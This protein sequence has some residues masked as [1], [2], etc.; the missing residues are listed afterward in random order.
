MSLF[1]HPYTLPA[2]PGERYRVC[3]ILSRFTSQ[4][5]HPLG[6]RGGMIGKGGSGYSSRNGLGP[7]RQCFSDFYSCIFYLF[8][9]QKEVL[10]ECC[11]RLILVR[12]VHNRLVCFVQ[13][14]GCIT[15]YLVCFFFLSV[16]ADDCRHYWR[17]CQLPAWKLDR[18]E[19]MPY[20]EVA[21]VNPLCRA[22]SVGHAA[23]PP[24][25][26]P[27]KRGLTAFTGIGR[28]WI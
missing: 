15:K 16:S 25:L 1:S 18:S 19:A 28:V 21:S 13:H 10:Y 20:T 3:L 22:P 24:P 26:P 14:V 2:S 5:P 7:L 6:W 9:P 4:D 23:Q 11:V 27:R 12:F 8:L 17:S